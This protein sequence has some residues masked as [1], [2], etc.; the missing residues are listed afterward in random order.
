MLVVMLGTTENV[1]LEPELTEFQDQLE[2]QNENESVITSEVVSRNNIKIL[3]SWLRTLT[4]KRMVRQ[5][6]Y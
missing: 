4:Q 1:R 3:I 5:W 6:R 2:G